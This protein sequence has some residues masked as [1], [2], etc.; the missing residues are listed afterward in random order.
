ML[1][2]LKTH[3]DDVDVE[4]NKTIMLFHIIMTHGYYC[5]CNETNDIHS[6]TI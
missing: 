3:S 5:D 6:S 1:Q 4:T 2:Y